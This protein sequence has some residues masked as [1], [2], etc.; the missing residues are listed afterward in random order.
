V[1]CAEDG[2]QWQ[3]LGDADHIPTESCSTLMLPKWMVLTVLTTEGGTA[4]RRPDADPDDPTP[5]GGTKDQ[6]EAV[7]TASGADDYLTKPL[8]D[9]EELLGSDQSPGCAQ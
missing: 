9:I 1:E 6:G 3:A 5:E 2:N 4:A 7:S 8:N